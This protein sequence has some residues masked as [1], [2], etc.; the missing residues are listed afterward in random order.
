MA[1][2]PCRDFDGRFE[3]PAKGRPPWWDLPSFRG[4]RRG[5]KF[6]MVYKLQKLVYSDEE[7]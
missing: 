4:S 3:D 7:Q 6:I 1:K 2:T 5:V